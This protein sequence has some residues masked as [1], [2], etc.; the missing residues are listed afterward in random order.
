[1]LRRHALMGLAG[2]ALAFGFCG[3]ALAEDTVK[4]G[5]ILPMTG[6]S[7]STGREIE[8]AVKLYMQQNGDKVAGKKIEVITRDD[9]G[10]ADITKRLAQE[11][12]VNDKVAVIAGFGLTP[13]ALAAG[14]IA[15]QAKVPAVIMAAGTSMIVDQSP[16]FVRTSF[17]LPQNTTPMAE[18]AAKNG[19]KKVV[20]LVSDYGP[21]IDA[22]KAFKDKFTADGGQ[23]LDSLRAPLR[24]PE[25]A[26]FLQKAKD[27]KPDALFLFVPSGFGASLMK[28][29]S[30]RQFKEA[31]I[32][33][34]GTG[35]VLD[36]E[37]LNGMGDVVLGMI[38][39][40]NYS[41]AHDS[42]ENKKYVADFEKANPNM[43]PNFMSVGGYDGIGL[44][45][46]A[47][48]KTG[49]DTT[50][51]KLLDAMK[52]LSWTSPRGPISIDPDTR[53]IVQNV[54]IRKAE[55]KDGQIYNIEFATIPNVKDPLHG[56]K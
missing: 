49:G 42:P 43:R 48:E 24:N 2:A 37:Q 51:T 56:K 19:I 9:T 30:E 29:V 15:T 26:P 23:V 8:A 27:L 52:G 40:M 34:I 55:K 20:T 5:L 16:F 45:Y 14:P 39:S 13:L 4:I 7:A 35:D 38:T 41:A 31:G 10:Q 3:S 46:K 28:Q 47:L 1:M 12:V 44:I 36:D 32:Q 11:L 33:V 22:E 54:Y 53:D 18:W 25:F 21:G 6:P 17:T 50:G